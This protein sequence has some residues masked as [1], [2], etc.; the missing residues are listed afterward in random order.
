MSPQAVH[1]AFIRQTYALARAAVTRGNHPFGALLVH[2]NAV[3]ASAENTVHTA[4]DRTRHAELNLLQQAAVALPD[5]VLRAATL[6]TSTEPC[7]MCS[8]AIYWAG[9]AVVVFGTSATALATVAGADFLT[10]CRTVFARGTRTVQVIGPVC[11]D[12]GLA[13]H[14][15]YWPQ[16]G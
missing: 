9:I 11:E 1:E 14:T 4:T 15:G 12:E 8:A 7:M 6:Y 16:H 3:V 5:A 10:P 2:N 13:I